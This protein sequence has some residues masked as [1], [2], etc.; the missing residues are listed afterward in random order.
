MTLT[1]YQLY[2]L[3]LMKMG[4]T[5]WWPAESKNEI[6]CEAI[7]IQNTNS[8]NAEQAADNLRQKTAFNG[9]TLLQISTP[10]LENLIRPAGFF[11]NKSRAIQGFFTWY[12]SF[13]FQSEAVI[14]KYGQGLRQELLSLRGIGNETADVFLT[15]VFDQPTFIAD[16]YARTLFTHLGITGLAKYED[17]AKQCQ[18]DS[19]FSVSDAQEFHG[20][21]DEFGK[22]YFRRQ[23]RFTDS[24]LHGEQ[25]T[26]HPS[27]VIENHSL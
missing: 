1:L 8:T 21:I 23:D 7:L 14:K 25:L 3:M 6:I 11:K 10:E 5:G 9:Q 20:L 15:Y 22:Q 16:K 24:F 27:D 17:L 4:P 2:K 26:L 18:L 12:Q 13:D 19:N